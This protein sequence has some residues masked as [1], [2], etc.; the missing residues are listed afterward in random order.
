MQNF[1]IRDRG[2]LAVRLLLGILVIITGISWLFRFVES[3][4]LSELAYFIIL[5]SGGVFIFFHG[6]KI[7]KAEIREVFGGVRIKWI[8]WLFRKQVY[9]VLVDSIQLGRKSIIINMYGRK[10]VRLKIET[11]SPRQKE[12]IY[13]YFIRYSQEHSIKV[14]RNF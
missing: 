2:I 12:K 11:F 4:R 7:E 10:P 1:I 13:N 9:H 3:H 8:N 14:S 5:F 6:F